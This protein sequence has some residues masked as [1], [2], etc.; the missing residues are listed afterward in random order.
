M[1]C[2]GGA[3]HGKSPEQKLETMKAMLY[4]LKDIL[5]DEEA[6]LLKEAVRS[7]EEFNVNPGRSEEMRHGT[8]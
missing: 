4:G 8:T 6:G 3:C 2:C 1:S 5:T 7:Y